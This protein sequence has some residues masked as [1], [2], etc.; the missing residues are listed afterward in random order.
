[1]GD[2]LDRQPAGGGLGF[3]TWATTQHPS[4][5]FMLA[6]WGMYHRV[7]V[8]TDKSA[9]YAGVL[10]QLKSHPLVKA[11]VYF[12][13]ASDDEGDRDISVNS[14]PG[15]LTAFRTLAADPIFTVRIGS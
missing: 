5:P 8:P 12:D 13:T 7:K 15:S 10:P 11:I 4:K 3:Y 2:I 1:M 9:A 6:E 14:L